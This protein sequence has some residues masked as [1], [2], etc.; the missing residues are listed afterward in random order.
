MCQGRVRSG[1][2]RHAR[3]TFDAPRSLHACAHTYGCG[4]SEQLTRCVCVCECL[5][6]YRYIYRRLY[7]LGIRFLVDAPELPLAQLA[8]LKN[9][10]TRAAAAAIVVYNFASMFE[11]GFSRVY[12]YGLYCVWVCM[13]ESLAVRKFR[14]LDF[15]YTISGICIRCREILSLRVYVL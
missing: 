9:H 8:M 11:T 3:Q 13:R 1:I 2:S 5:R 12:I 6:V 7:S 14:C 10:Q 4:D 15:V